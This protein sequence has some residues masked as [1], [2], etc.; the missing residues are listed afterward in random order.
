MTEHIQESKKTQA[1]EQES[2]DLSRS[3]GVTDR[4]LINV[5]KSS[6]AK[7]IKQSTQE[8]QTK[9]LSTEDKD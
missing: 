5:E 8:S 1:E 7:E 6:K 3:P 9:S 2:N 4:E